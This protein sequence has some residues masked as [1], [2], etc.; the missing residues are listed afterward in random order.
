[1]SALE[2]HLKEHQSTP[3]ETLL[4]K[5]DRTNKLNDSLLKAHNDMVFIK[6]R[7]SKL[8]VQ[9]NYLRQ[10]VETAM[11]N[12]QGRG[13]TDVPRELLVQEMV[14]AKN[15]IKKFRNLIEEVAAK[16]KQTGDADGGGGLH[17]KEKVDDPKQSL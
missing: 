16:T 11:P 8:V 12:S 6:S 9:M 13:T 15:N 1:M 3:Y 14:K 4:S 5:S 2:K 7:V 10:A 17:G